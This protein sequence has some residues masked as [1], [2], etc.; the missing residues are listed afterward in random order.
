MLKTHHEHLLDIN[1]PSSSIR[2]GVKYKK[3]WVYR[4]VG[5][6]NALELANALTLAVT[7]TQAIGSRRQGPKSPLE[8]IVSYS[9]EFRV[10]GGC[11]EEQNVNDDSNAAYVDGNMCDPQLFR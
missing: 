5:L 7:L 6:A 4:K 1:Q 9:R 8:V 11:K 2:V 3:R 10:V